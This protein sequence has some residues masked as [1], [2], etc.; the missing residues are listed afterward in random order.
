MFL[1]VVIPVGNLNKD[2]E[3]LKSII[4]SLLKIEIEIEIEIVFV[5]DTVEEL[6]M[7]RLTE[8]CKL[9]RLKSYKI[10]ECADRNPGTSRN[11]GIAATG[12]EW[13]VFCDSDDMPIFSNLQSAMLQANNDCDIVIGSF[14]TENILKITTPV[15][16]IEDDSVF[17]WESISLNPGVWRWLIRKNL[18]SNITFPELSI[19]EDQF[20]LI[21]L[22]SINPSIEFSSEIFYIYRT[23]AKDRLTNNKV[24]IKDLAEN[25]KLELAYIKLIRVSNDVV[26]NMI[27]RQLATLYKRGTVNLKFESTL[28]FAKFLFSLSP[29]DYFSL[30]KF[31]TRILKTKCKK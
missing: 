17:N 9:E 16:L 31:I 14:E 15:R 4:Q 29:N 5:L 30:L 28:L 26:N 24:K 19:G 11:V 13:I 6:A 18:L 1:S 7:L 23:G 25:L 27:L 21:K 8:L 10:L 2:Y 20:F 12:G 22:L 3:N